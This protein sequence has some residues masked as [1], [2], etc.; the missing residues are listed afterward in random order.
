LNC[1]ES[2]WHIALNSFQLGREIIFITSFI[3]S[4]WFETILICEN[5]FLGLALSC[6]V[7]LR[8]RYYNK[9]DEQAIKP[10]H[11]WRYLHCLLE[12]NWA[13]FVTSLVECI[14]A[15]IFCYFD[16]I[17]IDA[18]NIFKASEKG[19]VARVRALVAS[20]KSTNS[21]NNVRRRG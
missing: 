2:L 10:P 13:V 15:L 9:N 7:F 11:T 1:I 8:V 6:L 3:C 16:Y 12:C 20:G 4:F 5:S 18:D 14:Y 17:S 19:D 21:Q